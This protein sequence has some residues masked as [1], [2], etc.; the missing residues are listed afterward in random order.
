MADLA[1]AIFAD[2]HFPTDMCALDWD[3]TSHGREL[4]IW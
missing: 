3:F 4:V 2:D 1:C